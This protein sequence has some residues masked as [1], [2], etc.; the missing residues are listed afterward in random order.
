MKKFALLMA[1]A[2]A[3]VLCVPAKAHRVW[4]QADHVHGGEV[5]RA[6]LG[7]GEFPKF[8]PIAKT[9]TDLFAPLTLVTDKGKQ[10]LVQKDAKNYRY[11]SKSPVQEGSFLLLAEYKPTF[12][13]KN[14]AGWQ[15]QN[16]MQMPDASYCEQ[17][18]MYGKAV[19]NVGHDSADT[20]VITR[21]VGQ[22]LEMVPLDNPANVHVGEPLAVRVLYRGEPLANH[23]VSATFAG[24]DVSDRSHTHKESAQAFFDTTNDDG[25]VHI[26]PLRQGFWQASV[27]YKI[28][29][30]D[31][32]LCQ[33][34]ATYSTL[35]FDI[36]GHHH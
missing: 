30:H 24:F 35:T 36:G 9:R 14:G 1:C 4:V 17:T 2:A 10:T 32:K 28:D 25:V 7:Y 29:F 18:R 27:K 5:L 26:I 23:P 12:W 6:N 15:R 8:E 20:A 19:V 22:L 3:S 16:L 13:S 34:E 31:P 33:H 21:P 11:Q